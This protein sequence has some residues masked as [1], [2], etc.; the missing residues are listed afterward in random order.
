[1]TVSQQN[2]RSLGV[3]ALSAGFAALCGIEASAAPPIR[4]GKTSSS[5]RIEYNKDIRPILSEN[6]F[7]CHGADSAARKA[8]LRL[9]KP[10]AEAAIKDGSAA[11]VPG[12]PDASEAIRRMLGKGPIMPPAYTHKTLKPEQ[13]ALI[14]AWVKQGAQ[15]QPHWAYIA[16]VKPALPSVSNSAWAKSPI[17]RFVLAK[18]DT[19]GLKPAAEAD[20]RTLIRRVSLDTTGLPPEPAEVSRF[21][22]DHSPNAYEKMVDRMLASPRY[23]EHRARYWLDVCRYADTNGIHFD[24]YREVWAYREWVIRAFNA[25]MPFDRFTIEQL[26][27]DLLP[28]PTM[29]QKIATGFTRC[30]ITTNEGGAIDEE[31]RVL[32]A[33]DR[34][35]TAAQI[36]LGSTM[37]CCVCHDHKFDP[38]SMKDF[39]SMSAY[40]NN[41]TQA[42]MDGN[43]KDTPPVLFVP[44]MQDRARYATIGADITAAQ[45]A[46]DTRKANARADFDAWIKS[47]RPDSVAATAA[48]DGLVTSIALNEGKGRALTASVNGANYTLTAGAD[49][50]WVS[51]P[52]A[53]KA[54]VKTPGASAECPLIG[55]FDTNQA[56]SYAAWIKMPKNGVGGSVYARMDDLHDFRGWDLWLEYNKI[57]THII[58][59]WPESALKVVSR[60]PLST[61]QWHHVCIAYPGTGKAA[62]VRIYVDGKQVEMDIASDNLRG[63]IKT[64]VPFKIGQRHTTS[65][66]DGL[67]IQDV[68]I[69]NRGLDVRDAARIG[70]GPRMSYL[71]AKQA[72]L[73]AAERDE[74]FNW[75]L[76]SADKE[77]IAAAD[78]LAA[79]QNENSGI[80]ARGATTHIANEQPTPAV[81]YILNRG[82]YDKRREK[83]SPAPPSSL[84]AIPA[85]FP[86][87]RLGL[88]KWFMLPENP[89]TAR[90]T[91]NRMWQE[92]FGVGLVKSAGDFGVNGEIPPNQALL[93]YLAID[94]R[95]HNWDVKRM[96]REI[97]LSST[98]KQAAITTPDKRRLDQEN[99]YCSR[100]PRF[101]MDAEMVRDYALAVSTLLSPKIGGPSVRPYQPTG[102]WEAVA[103][104]ESNTRYYMQDKGENLYRRSMYTFWKRAAPP[105]SMDVFNAPS[106]ETCTVRRERTN[107]PLQALVTLN[108]VQFV[109]AA[110][111]LAQLTLKQGGSTDAARINYMANRL[112][113]RPFTAQE[114]AIVQKSLAA[115]STHYNSDAA[116]AKQLISEGESKA[117]ATIPVTKLA[118]WTMLANQLMNLDEVLNK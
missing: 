73:T 50:S 36:W 13:I 114:M 22:S 72:T 27:G 40:F 19:L 3:L 15:Y 118:A 6:C 10:A 104:P 94:F 116:D 106:R 62:D 66:T 54:F 24:N 1:M 39:Y 98:Y 46:V 53:E 35:E 5:T 23:G 81:A 20:K 109:E 55:D 38:F 87:N 68:R 111:N 30:N 61:D 48:P 112:I 101:R 115:L 51:G 75:W 110:R 52:V 70:S 49:P 57:G 9:D 85:S 83:V 8:G 43:I 26:A 95:E 37:G 58:N 76:T 60:Q 64:T 91:V 67:T 34:T 89:L 97:M 82:E 80:V 63:T 11:I 71:V 74:A 41:T 45:K 99:R 14:K 86:K 96:Y 33:R 59:K 92:L 32:Y 79:L 18:L 69:Y 108:D 103:M 56:F 93:D 84:P 42:A 28:N 2:M 100:G 90:V 31:Y 16:P 21:L 77:F 47:A 102:V 25:N 105:A 113:S 17:D 12:K 107:T 117:D 88:A 29:D 4:T 44:A 65:A 7:S 78:K